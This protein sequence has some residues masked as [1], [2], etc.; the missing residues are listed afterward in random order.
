M[1][2]P[3]AKSLEDLA[4]LFK[5]YAPKDKDFEPFSETKAKLAKYAKQGAV[6]IVQ[7]GLQTGLTAASGASTMTVSVGMASIALFPLGA[8]LGPWLAAAAIASKAESIFALHD[9]R[10][11]ARTNGVIKCTCGNC[12]ANLT[13]VIDRKENNTAI[14]AVGVFTAGIAIIA[15]RLNSVRKSFQKNRPKD[16]ICTSIV[17]GARG[18]CI[19]AIAAVIMIREEKDAF[20]DAVAVIWASDGALRL[21]SKW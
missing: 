6:T 14:L 20:V 21:K 7:T 5:T 1:K 11:S 13:Y 19:C 15:D 2:L 4:K 9:L 17:M 16:K 8:A 3:T 12:V 10:T 18:G